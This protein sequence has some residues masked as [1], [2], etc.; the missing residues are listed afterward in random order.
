M[1]ADKVIQ[2][3]EKQ[4][5][6]REELLRPA[7]EFF[8]EHEGK[9]FERYEAVEELEKHLEEE[10][11]LPLEGYEGDTERLLHRVIANLASD[12]V[13]PVQN[14]VRE[15][16]K[17]VGVLDY[18]EHD[19]WYEYVEV[20]DVHGRMNVGV[21]AQC[22]KEADNDAQVAKGVGTTEELESKIRQHYDDEHSESP[23]SVETGAT[24]VSGTTIAGNTAIHSGNDGVGSGLNADTFR[25]TE[26]SK[27]VRTG[28][29][30][31]IS[32]PFGL[33]QSKF[34]SPSNR[35]YGL[36]VDSTDCI[37]NADVGASSIYELNQSGTVLS[38]IA[39]P[40]GG[41]TGV[42]IDSTDCIWNADNGAN[43][44]YELNQSGTVQSG[45][46]SP[47]SAPDGVDADSS[48]CIWNADN[49]SNSIYELN[50]S[51]TVQSGF[52]SPSSAPQGLGVG[53]G[54]CIWNADYNDSI[55]Q[56]DQSGTV[57]SKFTT[58]SSGGFGVG[59]DSS[60]CIWHA[61]RL[62]DSIYKIGRGVNLE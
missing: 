16:A 51:G 45:F 6:A 47:S 61:N 52:A 12:R 57:T 13:D 27:F 9:L 50:Q 30:Y 43:S 2:K 8:H 33:V 20:D 1:D 56:L 18:A 11:V 5:E 22:V 25:G 24:L 29:N 31:V 44:I 4:R 14:V 59:L 35:P 58:P 10:D 26:A 39:S 19:F 36:G 60:D 34:A 17:Y 7:A 46:A 40:S 42:G 38:K 37:W 41:P 62:A 53:S 32:E 23:E 49:A 21:C 55:Y 15:N 48:D 28:V 3:A 54:D